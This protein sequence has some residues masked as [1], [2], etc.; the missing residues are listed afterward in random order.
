V[1][2]I[3]AAGSGLLK[4]DQALLIVR[5]SF[6]AEKLTQSLNGLVKQQPMAWKSFKQGEAT[7]YEQRDKTRPLPAYV[8]VRGDGVIL[9]SA[10]KKYV[11][12]ALT[13]DPKKPGKVSETLHRLVEKAD[14]ADDL[15]MVSV[16]SEAI[17]RVL[18]KSTYT[19]GIAD[20]VTAFTARLAIREDAR[21]AFSV[22]TKKKTTAEEVAQLLD[23]AK[24]LV[25]IV[26]QNSDG[27]G[28]LLAELID[29]CKTTTDGGTATLSGQLSE[30]QI[31]KALKKK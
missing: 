5:G 11:I 3:T 30:E 21:I 27:V 9:L 10:G 17:H 13:R 7:L 22:H 29:A 6:D 2:S 26:A 24:G 15:W 12:N 31:A 18:A 4:Y 8:A 19:Q 28:P 14:A 23:A 16:R 20:E 1:A 25:S